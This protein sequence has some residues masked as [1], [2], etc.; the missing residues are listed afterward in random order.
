MMNTEKQ[1]VSLSELEKTIEN[2]LRQGMDLME[3][4]AALDII[5]PVPNTVIYTSPVLL[6]AK[7]YLHWLSAEI[8]EAEKCF[9]ELLR[10][11]GYEKYKAMGILLLAKPEELPEKALMDEVKES[12]IR[13]ELPFFAT[14][15]NFS[16]LNGIKDL[17]CYFEDDAGMELLQGI[18]SF[19][20]ESKGVLAY[21]LAAAESLYLQGKHEKAAAL[22]EEIIGK[23]ETEE[24]ITSAKILL[25]KILRFEDLKASE[26]ILNGLIN[27]NKN[28]NL[29]NLKT[30]QEFLGVKPKNYELSAVPSGKFYSITS[31]ISYVRE[32]IGKAKYVSAMQKCYRLQNITNL[33]QRTLD[34]IRIDIL[35]AKIFL[36]ADDRESAAETIGN[37]V[38]KALPYRYQ[39]LFIDEG[40]ETAEIIEE[41]IKNCHDQ[42]LVSFAEEILR[43]FR[44]FYPQNIHLTKREKLILKCLADKLRNNEIAA[45]LNITERTVKFHTG[46]LYQKLGVRTRKEAAELAKRK[47][48][49]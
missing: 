32:L 16:V 49:V 31:E 1:N 26:E 47:N 6:F 14:G 48:L 7:L 40:S 24:L 28:L 37:A 46:N 44:K 34:Q 38:A 2:I 12:V 42:K 9:A 30:V 33:Y 36:F 13:E 19:L 20:Y 3:C 27:D 41:F 5:K 18:F 35:M 29:N 21:K 17:S 45:K 25:A 8:K 4:E 43:A 39:M 23:A 11:E 10:M 22:I 15:G